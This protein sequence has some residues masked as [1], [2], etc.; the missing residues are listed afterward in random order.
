MPSSRIVARDHYVE[1]HPSQMFPWR[2]NIT[3]GGETK[4]CIGDISIC[5][6]EDLVGLVCPKV[7]EALLVLV[8]MISL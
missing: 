5:R 8:L 7:G 3:I 1:L 2:V 4:S 6:G